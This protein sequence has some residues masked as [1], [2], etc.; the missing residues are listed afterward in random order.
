MLQVAWLSAG[1]PICVSKYHTLYVYQMLVQAAMYATPSNNLVFY[2]ALLGTATLNS[3]WEYFSTALNL[4]YK[5]EL[6]GQAITLGHFCT[7]LHKRHSTVKCIWSQLCRKLC[8]FLSSMEVIRVFSSGH[9]HIL[10]VKLKLSRAEHSLPNCSGMYLK[11]FEVRKELTF[12]NSHFLSPLVG[13]VKTF[14]YF[15]FFCVI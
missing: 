15:C 12:Q 5:W 13:W 2:L 10:R 6:G 11:D 4:F 7:S 1:H 3:C 14:N 9:L 8:S